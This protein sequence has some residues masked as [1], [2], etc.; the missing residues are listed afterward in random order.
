MYVVLGGGIN[1]CAAPR[2]WPCPR[3]GT[4]SGGYGNGGRGKVGY[5]DVGHGKVSDG[6]SQPL[7]AVAA[8]AEALKLPPQSPLSVQW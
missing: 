3:R 8:E 4:C 1:E 5:G 2:S 7:C 6:D